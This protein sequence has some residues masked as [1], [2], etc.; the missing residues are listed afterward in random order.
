[1]AI[2]D[3]SH[4]VKPGEPL[5]EDAYERATSVYFP[6]RVIPMLP[7][8]LSNGL[9]SL[10]PDE[11]RLAMVCDMLVGEDGS[12]DAYQ[13]YP[14]VIC[15][16]ARLTYTEVAA[17]LG[18]TR[19]PEAQRRADLLPH[20]LHLH[21]VYRALLKQRGVR[22]AMDFDTTETQIVC[23]EQGRIAKI[24]PRTRTEAHR[25]IEEAMLAANVCAADFIAGASHASLFR[26]HEGPTPEKRV[27]LQNYLRALG[28][29]LHL[30]DDPTPLEM[31][32]IAKATHD[33]P[34]A[35]QIHMML[36]RSMQ[37]AIYTAHNSGH[38][39][40]AYEAY[41]HFT[42]PIRRYPDLLVHRVIKA[43]LGGRKYHLAPSPK[44]RT[45]EVRRGGKAVPQRQVKP[46]TQEMALWEAAGAHCSAN[47]RRADEAT[48]DVE[49]W[50]KC[51]YMRERLG[52]QF[53]GTVSAVTGFGL[54]VTLDELYVDGLVHIT[55]L[56]GEYYRFDEARQELRGERTGVRYGVGVRVQVQVSRVDLDARRIDFRLVRDGEGDRLLERGRAK[57]SASPATATDELAAVREADRKAKTASKQRLAKSASGGAKGRKTGAAESGGKSLGPSAAV[58][59]DPAQPAAAAAI[60]ST[61]S[62]ARSGRPPPWC[63]TW[64]SAAR[65][66]SQALARAANQP[67]SPGSRA[68]SPPIQPASTSP[69]PG[70]ASTALPLPLIHGACR[71]AA[72]TVPEPL[73][74]T[75]E[76]WRA[77]SSRAARRRSACTSACSCPAAVR[78][79]AGAVSA[80]CGHPD[81]L[82]STVGPGGWRRPPRRSGHRRPAP[83]AGPCPAGGAGPA[84]HRCRHHSRRRRRRAR[85]CRHRP[86]TPAR[87]ASARA[88]QRAAAAGPVRSGRPGRHRTP[89]PRGPPARRRLPCPA[90]HRPRT[91]HRSCPCAGR[92]G[93]AAGRARARP[94]WRPARHWRVRPAPLPGRPA[95]P[96]PA[97]SRPA[98]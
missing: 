94:C 16:H 44:T 84:P 58:G 35:A 91:R 42:S 92:A 89:V 19:G 40:L 87:V 2:A 28:L 73:S 9:C 46:L 68:H 15:S 72:M 59:A 78:P 24:V 39:G 10:N 83:G 60:A 64:R 74:S 23:D 48:R 56:G 20:L 34:D 8:K 71:P 47:E 63:R 3:V 96:R 81:R 88:G 12:L 79:P 22:G 76:R 70:A 7:E 65:P 49:A 52:E 75:T 80:R 21:E 69:L 11:E 6:R 67:S 36:L 66:C 55:E 93:A 86:A 57:P 45:P 77:A 30:S 13:F 14:A 50:L 41:T 51:R 62:L 95:T 25:L 38:F 43:L 5:D 82:A 27:T 17:V 26:V 61:R 4:Y 37:Q 1:V 18:N 53:S 90:R 98:P 32:A 31:A 54:F 85:R 97:W 29:G 33:R